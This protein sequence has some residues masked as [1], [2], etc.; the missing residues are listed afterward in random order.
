MDKPFPFKLIETADGSHTL[1][2][3]GRDEQYHSL[4]G[5][6]QESQHVFIQTGLKSAQLSNE[7]LF[8]LEVGMGT[9]LNA[10]L[11]GREAILTE[12]RILYDAC[13]A[14]PLDKA[15]I[16]KLNYPS[17]FSE[18]GMME[19]FHRIHKAGSEKYENIDDWFF[20][21]CFHQKIEEMELTPSKYNLVYFDAFGPDTQPEL[22]SET[23]FQKVSQ[24]MKPGGVLVTYSVKGSVR[25]AMESAGL[26]VEKVPGPPGKRE[27]SRAVKLPS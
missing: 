18:E 19:L 5:A 20:I 26:K 16:G 4:N 24:S 13:E 3:D 12:R 8:V 2:L 22:W 9:G 17:M 7:P 21:R 14:Y 10:L 27:I 6:L 1:K 23:V 11:T 15:V 25:R